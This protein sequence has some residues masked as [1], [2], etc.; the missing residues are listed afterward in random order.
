MDDSYMHDFWCN[1]FGSRN[2]SDYVWSFTISNSGRY[3]KLR[4]NNDEKE[5][6][7]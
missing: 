6:E 4:G 7:R 5:K 2:S 1:I 3:H